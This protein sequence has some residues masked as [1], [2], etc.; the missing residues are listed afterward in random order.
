MPRKQD[1][2]RIQLD[3]DLLLRSVVDGDTEELVAFKGD[4]H[5]RS[6]VLTPDTYMMDWTRDLLT[7]PHPT[8]PR[9]WFLVVEDQK[10]GGIVSSLSL[11]P[12]TWTY[13]GVPFPVGRVEM[14]STDPRYRRLGLVRHQ[15]RV[16]H[17]WGDESG[18]LAQ[19]ILGIPWYYRQF[20]YEYAVDY[21]GSRSISVG[22][23]DN[24]RGVFR[25][26]PAVLDD[27]PFIT[28]VSALGAN[29][30]AVTGL[31]N[32]SEWEYELNGKSIPNQILVLETGSTPEPAHRVGL[33]VLSSRRIDRAETVVHLELDQSVQWAEVA[34]DILA[35]FRDRVFGHVDSNGDPITQVRLSL[36]IDHP[37]YRTNETVQ[38]SIQ[39]PGAWYVRIAS[40][41]KFL[42]HVRPV[43]ERRLAISELAGYS[44]ELLLHFFDFGVELNFSKGKMHPARERDDLSAETASAYFPPGVFLQLLFGRRSL[45]ELEYAYPDVKASNADRR[46]LLN[47]LFPKLPSLVFPLM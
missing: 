21:G 38:H 26:R 12:Q 4:T 13:G 28:Q 1:P 25:L 23:I 27:I 33:A 36:G 44:G 8:F 47:C 19:V 18:H 14:V 35:G 17:T 37:M 30:Y 20:G 22:A 29:R 34:S 32:E 40:L 7:R 9:E 41:T 24:G 6:G 16:A 5:R 42:D 43:L 11:I 3:R 31:R 46:M 39:K 45:E 15:M 2:L 10:S